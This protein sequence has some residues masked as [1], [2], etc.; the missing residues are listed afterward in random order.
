[1]ILIISHEQD[2]HAQEVMKRLKQVGVP[3][4]LFD[5][6][7]FPQKM[8]V[9]M[10]LEDSDYR[11]FYLDSVNQTRLDMQDYKVIWWRRPQPFDMGD[12]IQ[13]PV[14]LNFALSESMTAFSGM[15]RSLDAFWIN[16]PGHDDD[17]S[18]KLYQLRVAQEIGL[19]IPKTCITSNPQEAREFARQQVNQKTVYK[20][21]TG[22]RE[23]WRETR[24]LKPEELEL[25][26]E[27]LPLAPVIFQEYIEAQDDLRITV[28][29]DKI[30]SAGIDSQSTAY[31][32]D[33]RMH[34]HEVPMRA[35]NL[36]SDV[37]NKLLALMKHF[38]LVYGAIDMR[39]T[40]QGEYVFLEV[41]SAGQ[42]LFVEQK[43]GLPITDA[44]VALMKEKNE[45]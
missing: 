7:D 14:D 28:I 38:G 24:L 34:I 29:G 33:Y 42:W 15:W 22:T 5:Q 41:N 20:A 16:P 36:P 40:P 31:R 21:F 19:K 30:F 8:R 13:D 39:L 23:A 17:A 10:R 6:A 11:A 26:D 1:M 27:S 12:L 2:E 37:S 18:Y 4:T 35:F 32:V 9:T 25:M 3:F 43:T 44:L 45:G